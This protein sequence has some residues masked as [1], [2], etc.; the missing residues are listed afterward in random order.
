MSYEPALLHMILT[1]HPVVERRIASA[2]VRALGEAHVF[3]GTPAGEHLRYGVGRRLAV[4]RRSISKIFEI[5]PPDSNTP[6]GT[7]SIS[8]V[9]INLHGFMINL[10]GIFDNLAWAFKYR[11]DLP[12]PQNSVGLFRRETIAFLPSQIRDDLGSDDL[13]LWQKDY[14][15]VYRDSLA[16]RIPMYV[17]PAVF[18][19]HEGRRWNELEALERHAVAD[20]N[21]H[22]AL[23]Y[24]ETKKTIGS[25]AF[26]FLH[27]DHEGAPSRAIALHPQIL[28]DAVTVIE[29]CNN[30][31][32]HWH[33]VAEQ[34]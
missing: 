26:F 20:G 8:D 16:H 30:F 25:P 23:N 5:F 13:Q 21:F 32:D 19:D 31:F 18:N 34:R 7:D 33:S 2:Q 3:Q 17:P 15:K 11:H 14:L 24:S 4:L 12:I 1:E 22:Q 28:S 6:L 9:Q 10:S 29:V 27:S